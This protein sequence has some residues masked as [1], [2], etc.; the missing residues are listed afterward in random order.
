MEVLCGQCGKEIQVDDAQAGGLVECS[1]CHHQIS[2]P[3]LDGQGVP[4]PA[5]PTP[6]PDE[7]PG[8]ADQARAAMDRK[9]RV[10]CGQ[11][12]RGLRV[13]VRMAGK[14]THCPGC[15]ASIQIP[16]SEEDQKILEQLR[17]FE[18]VEA[19]PDEEAIIIEG[20]SELASAVVAATAPTEPQAETE[21]E[22]VADA[23]AVPVPIAEVPSP[24]SARVFLANRL[25]QKRRQRNAIMVAAIAVLAV[26]VIIVVVGL[27]LRPDGPPLTHSGVPTPTPTPTEPP[28]PSP[29]PTATPSPTPSPAPTP[30]PTPSP[31]PK[32]LLCLTSL[33]QF[34]SDY[35]AI[36]GYWPAKPGH[37]FWLIKVSLDVQAGEVNLK[38]YGPD[39]VIEGTSDAGAVVVPSLG[40]KDISAVLP[41]RAKAVELALR[42]GDKPFEPTFVFEVPETVTGGKIVLRGID[43][44]DLTPPTG[45][46]PIQAKKLLGKYAE[47]LPRNLRP[48]L[49]DPVMAALQADTTGRVTVTGK[50]PE[51]QIDFPAAG[52]TGTAK[53]AGADMFTAKLT[54]ADG[55]S[56]DCRLRVL[57]GG[58]TL[59]LFLSDQPFHQLTY[60]KK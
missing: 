27:A 10:V 48:Q 60:Q 45:P 58:S 1:R 14:Q 56:L 13:G 39:V 16:A 28:T 46:E 51:F 19:Q 30:S 20:L 47:V 26:G 17:K 34:K 40:I 50:E 8:F 21:A 15:Q 12:G 31:T 53:H 23:V 2:V 36:D 22:V 24:S 11:C 52:V 7:A 18:P 49:G 54:T 4:E 42:K 38:T 57:Y 33:L 6:P 32:S 29:S 41:A 25:R 59:V 44:I 43:G 35:F 55:Q 3:R 37:I 9:I 5:S